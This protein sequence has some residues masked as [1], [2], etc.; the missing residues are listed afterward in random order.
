MYNL[1]AFCL[2]LCKEVNLHFSLKGKAQI[3]GFNKQIT[4]E[5]IWPTKKT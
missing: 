4:E 1:T 5:D 2:F 3:K